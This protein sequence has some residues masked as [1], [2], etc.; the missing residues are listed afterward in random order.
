MFQT[1]VDDDSAMAFVCGL[2]YGIMGGFLLLGSCDDQNDYSFE[3]PPP[4]LVADANIAGIETLACA[5]AR[6]YATE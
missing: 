3:P 1:A 2:I 6:M 4:P 5:N